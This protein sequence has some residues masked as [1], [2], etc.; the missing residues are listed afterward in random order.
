[1]A[2]GPNAGQDAKPVA[3]GTGMK[4]EAALAKTNGQATNG[5]AIAPANGAANGSGTN[6]HAAVTQAKAPSKPAP[7]AA[8]PVYVAELSAKLLERSATA[9]LDAAGGSR[10]DQFAGFQVD[11]PSCDNCGMITVRNGNCYL[12]HNCGASMG[13]S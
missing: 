1:M 11:A 8:A 3:K 7:L 10:N 6:G 12:C 4:A 13:C 5:H 9:V 2:G